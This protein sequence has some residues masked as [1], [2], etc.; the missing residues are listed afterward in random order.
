MIVLKWIL[1]V[2]RLFAKTLSFTIFGIGG[3]ILAT[4]VFPTL[5]TFVFPAPRFRRAMRKAVGISFWLFALLMRILGLIKVNFHDRER[6][7]S[8]RGKVVVAN[9]PTLIDVVLIIAYVPQADCIVKAKLWSNPFVRGVVSSIYIPNSLSFE[10]TIE[11]CKRSF[12]EGNNL[13][14]FPEGTR[15]VPGKEHKLQRGGS[16]IALRTGTDILPIRIDVSNPR[17]LG[18]GDKF[19]TMPFEGRMIFDL[20]VLED[21]RYSDFALEDAAI[22]A[23]RLT[24]DIQRHILPQK[25]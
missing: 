3:L 20:H 15:T 23:R 8:A 10:E 25:F 22:G 2:W 1:Y 24:A 17:G 9:H 11:Q 12:A 5:R 18:K 19:F 4:V 16:Q 7:M 13:V 14:I 6:L 21:L